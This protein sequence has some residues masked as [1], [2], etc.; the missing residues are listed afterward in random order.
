QFTSGESGF[1]PLAW[2]DA[3]VDAH[4]RPV[5]VAA[6]TLPVWI[7]IDASVKHDSTAIVAVTVDRAAQQVVLVWHRI[8]Q[9]SPDDPV[10][11]ERDIEA[12]VLDLRRRFR[13]QAVVFD[14]YQMMGTAQRLA[15][16][17]VP[18]EEY[19]QSAD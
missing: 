18:I 14:P 8:I 17:R 13:V 1:L 7:G 3:C 4:A 10:S 15:A 19:P 2:W 6:P 11:F 5:L 12:T 9:P 16:V